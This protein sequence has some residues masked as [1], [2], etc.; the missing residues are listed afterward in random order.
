[1]QVE[2]IKSELDDNYQPSEGDGGYLV[3]HAV[4]GWCVCVSVR[5][6]WVMRSTGVAISAALVVQAFKLPPISTP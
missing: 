2:M 4:I 3:E 6:T 5:G 1:M